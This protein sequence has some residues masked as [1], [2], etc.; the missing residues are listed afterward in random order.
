MG[1]AKRPRRKPTAIGRLRPW[2]ISS[3]TSTVP[4]PPTPASFRHRKV[5]HRAHNLV[6]SLFRLP[7]LRLCHTSPPR[8]PVQGPVGLSGINTPVGNIGKSIFFAVIVGSHLQN[9]VFG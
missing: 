1:R 8:H 6:Q 9:F 4:G 5:R 2:S 3:S 7:I